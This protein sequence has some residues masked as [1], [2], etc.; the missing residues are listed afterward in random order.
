MP[1][2][3]FSNQDILRNINNNRVYSS[4][5][6]PHIEDNIDDIF[7]I[8]TI[9]DRLDLLAYTYYQDPTLWWIIAQANLE[10]LKKGSMNISSGIQLRIP[11]NLTKIFNDLE[12]I[13]KER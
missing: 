2:D 3:R 8:T 1:V 10:K 6:Y 11:K 9:T 5:L 7:I 13:N 4:T 12:K